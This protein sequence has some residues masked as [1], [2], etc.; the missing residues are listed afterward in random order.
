MVA[1]ANARNSET[2]KVMNQ[3]HEEFAKEKTVLFTKL[4]AVSEVT[5]LA[6]SPKQL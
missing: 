5:N 1:E 3:T 2:E 6:Q 4:Y